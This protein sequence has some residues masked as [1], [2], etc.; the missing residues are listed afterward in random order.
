M[1]II[2]LEPVKNLG[3]SGDKVEVKNGYARNFLIP[4][5]V[6][7]RANKD[8]LAVYEARK[9]E[10]EKQN[11]DKQKTAET[12]AKKI[13]GLNITVIRQAA[14]DG[15][16]F[17]SVTAREIAD[18]VKAK[19]FDVDSKSVELLS[20][21]R[22]LGVSKVRVS[23]HADVSAEISVNV[24]RSEGEAESQLEA[25]KA[26]TKEAN[27]KAKAAKAAEKSEEAAA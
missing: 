12:A 21:I 1:E 10:I 7:L 4:N 3:R 26:A 27:A 16:L 2:L 13:D 22:N 14:E 11:A 23:L 17:G 15:R 24:A 8:N 5:G 6:A 19:G 18:Q 9:A 25:D 20:P